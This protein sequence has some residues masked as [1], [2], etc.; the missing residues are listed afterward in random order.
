VDNFSVKTIT[1]DARPAMKF[2]NVQ[3]LAMGMVRA[4]GA[5]FSQSAK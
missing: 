2:D 3:N 4:N 1:P 5:D